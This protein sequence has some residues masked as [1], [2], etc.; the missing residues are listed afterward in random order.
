MPR[1][2]EPFFTT[3][4]IGKGTGLGL[5]Q[6]YGFVKQSGG[7]VSLNSETGKGTTV[8]ISFPRSI[9]PLVQAAPET[10]LD[11]PRLKSGTIMIV[12]DNDKVAEVTGTLLEHIGYRT[13]RA[14]SATDALRML[15]GRYDVDLVLTDIV[16]PGGMSGLDLARELRRRFPG[17]PVLLTTGY[18]AAA[19]EATEDGFPILSKPYHRKALEEVVASIIAGKEIQKRLVG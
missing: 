6:V 4:E 9:A 8:T 3:K 11:H 14:C 1:V 7:T 5:S 19:Q 18:S 12:E 17:L 2:F 16:M 13:H 15:L 10:A